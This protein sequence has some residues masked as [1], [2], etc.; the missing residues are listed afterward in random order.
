MEV[1][2]VTN[3][4]GVI[5]NATKKTDGSLSDHGKLNY[6][7]ELELKDPKDHNYNSSSGF[8][9]STNV[10]IP[11]GGSKEASTAPKGSTTIGLNSSGQETEQLTKATMGQGTVNT[12]AD[13]N[14][15]INNTQEITRDQTTGMLDGSVTID[16]RLLTESGRAEIIQQQKDLP[17]NFRQSAENV[18]KALPESEYK[19]QVLQ[20][21]NNVQAKLYTLPMQYKDTDTLGSEVVLGLIKQGVEPQTIDKLFDDKSAGMMTVLE[22]LN[23]LNSK[24]DNLKQQGLTIKDILG[25]DKNPSLAVGDE[26]TFNDYKV[27]IENKSTIGISLLQDINFIGNMITEISENTGV[28]LGDVQLAVGLM[29]SGPVR[30]VVESAKSL[31]MDTLVGPY[32]EKV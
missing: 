19:K 5:A 7:G 24:I 2:N 31:G 22:N 4:G 16:H 10:G 11:Q 25:A 12:T 9:I 28:N 27:G 1:K 26:I 32:K 23:D 6:S 14:R 15:D 20:T 13:T 30:L 8:N 3:I 17:E 18:I 29:I 21:L